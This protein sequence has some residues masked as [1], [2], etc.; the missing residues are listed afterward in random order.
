M[1]QAEN[2]GRRSETERR[3]EARVRQRRWRAQEQSRE[4]GWKSV[5]GQEV[6]E[7]RSR[8]DH[9]ASK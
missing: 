2:G 7:E 3:W 6:E 4:E 9:R 8:E 1:W 5:A